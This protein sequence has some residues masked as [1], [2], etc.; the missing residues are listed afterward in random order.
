ME[1]TFKA[2][3]T[4]EE[5]DKI[6]QKRLAQKDR[7]LAETIKGYLKP[8]EVEELKAD[9]EKQLLESKQALEDAK[10]K[11]KEHDAEVS[12]LKERAAAA[13]TT[14]LKSRIA[15][16]SG[17]PFEL[18]NRIVGTTEEELKKD[19]EALKAIITPSRVAPLATW[20]VKGGAPRITNTDP[21]MLALLGQL[22]EQM[23]STN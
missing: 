6:I 9:F 10:A 4:Q 17:L 2:I 21:S 12:S 15:H 23:A 5:L 18:A 13:E 20:D 19:A 3:E 14:L 8:E 11:L 1:N 22:N 16:E 7:E